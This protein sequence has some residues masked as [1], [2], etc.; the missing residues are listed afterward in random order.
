MK[1]GSVELDA[2]QE[3]LVKAR[4]QPIKDFLKEQGY[5]THVLVQEIHNRF[6]KGRSLTLWHAMYALMTFDSDF[7]FNGSG[8]SRDPRTVTMYEPLVEVTTPE[9]ETAS[10]WMFRAIKESATSVEGKA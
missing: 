5:G 10:D 6:N 2:D 9:P 8:I 7:V 3:K 4:M 1:I